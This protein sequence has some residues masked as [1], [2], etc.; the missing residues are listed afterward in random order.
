MKKIAIIDD[1]QTVLDVYSK[2]LGKDYDIVVAKDGQEGIDLIKKEK[3]DLALIDIMMPNMDGL[4]MIKKLKDEDLLNMPVV[5][6]T[7]NSEDENISKAVDLGVTEYLLKVDTDTHQI[8]Q[9]V[10]SLIK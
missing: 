3:P 7:N 10:N 9:K 1:E 2:I 6:L 8:L 5:I 4:E